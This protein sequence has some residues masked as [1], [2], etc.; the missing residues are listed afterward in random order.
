MMIDGLPRERPAFLVSVMNAEEAELALC[1]GADLIDCKDPNM[2]ALGALDIE[3][4]RKVVYRID[5]RVPVSATI[6]D[7][8]TEPRL[9]VDAAST[10][11]A[12]RV[13]I[14]KVGFFGDMDARPAISALGAASFAP[15][16]LVAVLMADRSPDFS[17]L[18]DLACAGFAGVMLDTADK[19]SG[20]LTSVLPGKRLREFTRSARGYGLFAGLAG[21]LRLADISDLMEFSPD[22]LGFRGALCISGRASTLDPAR[23]SE[24]RRYVDEATLPAT[25]REI[26]G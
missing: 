14:I 25:C 23:I 18:Y 8:P 19:A 12:T 17:L 20:R 3:I 16:R 13:D 22:V 2:G 21:S 5:G 24:V 15:C 6:G 26:V 11:A 9:M 7:L 4:V 1:G 10:M